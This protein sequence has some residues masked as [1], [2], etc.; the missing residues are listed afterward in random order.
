MD[1]VEGDKNH[2]VPTTQPEV[3]PHQ[4]KSSSP[5]NTLERR[6]DT[7]GK[8]P[9][10]VMSEAGETARMENEADAIFEE[11]A[12][13]SSKMEV[14]PPEDMTQGLVDEFFVVLQ[15]AR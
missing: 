11:L 10:S 5:N 1:R 12:A 9:S 6:I 13:L 7:A 8:I 14:N 3:V 2:L 4:T 15:G